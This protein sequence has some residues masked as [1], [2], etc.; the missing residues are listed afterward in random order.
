MP[1]SADP[2]P[3]SR[4]EAARPRPAEDRA[5]I[6]PDPSRPWHRPGKRVSGPV[7]VAVAAL[8]AAGLA[9][10][11]NQIFG[12]QIAG[13]QPINTGYYFL[14]F[15]LFVAAAFLTHPARG[16]VD[17]PATALDWAL[18]GTALGLGLW[19]STQATEILM[20][21][22][23]LVAPPG[24]TAAAAAVCLLALEGVRRAGGWLLFGI[25]L[26]FGL[27]PLVA[28]HMPGVLWGSQYAPA[29]LVRAHALGTESIFG[30]PMRV[31]SDII[32]G[33][34]VYGTALTLTGGGAFFMDLASALMGRSRG[35]P[36]K[37]SV[38]ASGFFGSL[39]GSVISNVI[40]T[41]TMTIPTMKRTGYS[42]AYAGAVESCASTGGA[43]TPPVMGAVA[44]VMASILNVPYAEV[45]TAAAVP[46]VLF[47]LALLLQADGYAARQ[48][49]GRMPAEDVPRLW[50]T[51]REGWVYL[52][53]IGL[54]IYIIL[55]AGL[56][57]QAPFYATALLVVAGLWKAGRGRRFALVTDFLAGT[58]S[59]VG[60]LVAILMGIGL[61]IGGLSL[62]GVAT[63]FSRELIQFAGGSTLLLLVLGAI[64]SFVLGMGMTSTACYIFLAVV[65]APALVEAG[66][67]P[68]ASHLFI[69]YWGMLSFI[70]PPV[71]LAAAAAA[72]V[73]GAP[74]LR[75]GVVAMRLGAPLFVLPFL[76]V[77]NPTLILVGAPGEIALSLFTAAL[78]IWMLAAGFERWLHGMGAL[79][80]P[81]AVLAV[82]GA[83]ALLVPEHRTDWLGLVALAVL[84]GWAAVTRRSGTRAPAE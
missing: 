67:N 47:Y 55:G 71:A 30:I 53:S 57:A 45:V 40:S 16:P 23:D 27:Y 24:V 33:F 38:I 14:V 78:A 42:P 25:C 1:R 17:T 79:T 77:L 11:V 37:V 18:A 65:L 74:A 28:D 7:Y 76:F 48:G 84:Y 26:V 4:D 31:V 43:L 70:T 39:S 63:A 41:G 6:A 10:T 82:S 29:E 52:A 83:L 46:A 59:A 2:D 56:E 58:A 21:G 36:A 5:A 19:L 61:I 75:T 34:I 3:T 64:T 66:L 60:N 12:L 81:Q 51:L 15:A 80:W 35:G 72:Q 8:G 13:F 69:L 54:L 73:A 68:M 62:T 9:L 22:W 49:L 44:F 20:R 50:P 32:L